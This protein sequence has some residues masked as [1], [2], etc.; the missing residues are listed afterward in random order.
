MLAVA[1]K[2]T[3]QAN[4]TGNGCVWWKTSLTRTAAQNNEFGP[5]RKGRTVSGMVAP[6]VFKVEH[7]AKSKAICSIGRT[8]ST[9]QLRTAHFEYRLMTV[10]GCLMITEF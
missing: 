10:C 2:S 1:S 9:C 8:P 7:L 5:L 6:K 4:G 3:L